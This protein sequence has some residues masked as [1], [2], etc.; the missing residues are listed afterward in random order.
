MP[1]L[2]DW[3]PAALRRAARSRPPALHLITNTRA[4]P[5]ERAYEVVHGAARA[6]LQALPEA[7][8]LLRGDSTLRAH[9]LEEYLA[10]RDA[11]YPGR[12]P[13]LLLVPAL[14]PAGRIT[15]G[16]VHL[17]ERGG[18]RTPL[19]E[20]EYARDPAFGYSDARLLRWAEERSG[21][22]FPAQAGRELHLEE[23]RSRGSTAVAATLVELARADRPAVCAPDAET[24]E[25]LRLIADGL[26][27]AEA[28]RA[29]VIV[30]SAPTF[31]GVLARNLA[32]EYAAVPR[33]RRLLVI[34]GSYVPA[35]TRQLEQV[36]VRHPD[37]L[38]EAR[39]TVLASG[40]R[41]AE[42]EIRR[43]AREA[44]R[45]M[46]EAGVAVVA[47][48]RERA[49]LS[50]E[51]AELLAAN[52]ARVLARLD[53]PPDV[54]VAKGGITSAVTLR[55]G[56]HA[57]EAWVVGP[58]ADGVSLWQVASGAESVPYIVFPGNVGEDETLADIVTRILA[59]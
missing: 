49:S 6:V 12:D 58:I 39:A 5:P 14:P 29:A 8:I 41:A 10:V 35:T 20:T 3:K 57:T 21:G 56:L 28:E 43:T 23:L 30:R 53:P 37:S 2:L 19:H 4:F 50:L 46:D 17:L 47:T 27:L 44:G 45:R 55:E 15:V 42:R 13:V 24:V 34:C 31:V 51:Q 38:V 18:T 54:V 25:D 59:G 1:I 36:V 7:R 9:M 11:A 52:L 32:T 16:G 22:H 48:P 26:E 40:G 33:G